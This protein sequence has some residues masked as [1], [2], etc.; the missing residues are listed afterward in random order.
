MPPPN[1][2]HIAASDRYSLLPV[3]CSLLLNA[4]IARTSES[5]TRTNSSF[6]RTNASFALVMLLP[7]SQASSPVTHTNEAFT[8]AND[9]KTRVSE[10]PCCLA[11]KRGHRSTTPP[12]PTKQVNGIFLARSFFVQDA[13]A[14]GITK[15]AFWFLLLRLSR[16]EPLKS[17][18]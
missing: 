9:S 11:D 2:H 3:A 4:S 7:S 12:I 6:A 10:M 13:P 1:S 5:M 15:S 16:S 17:I 14:G 18:T 8:R